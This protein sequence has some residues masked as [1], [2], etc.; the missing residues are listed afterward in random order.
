[1]KLHNNFEFSAKCGSESKDPE[2][3]PDP[4]AGILNFLELLDPNPDPFIM[5]TDQQP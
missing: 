4:G 1:M 2:K 5:H 3:D